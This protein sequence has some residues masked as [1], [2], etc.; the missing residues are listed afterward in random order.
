MI[1]YCELDNLTSQGED[2]RPLCTKPAVFKGVKQKKKKEKTV[3][4]ALFICLC[5]PEIFP[6]W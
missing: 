4:I 2:D 1:L 6:F 5:W 3:L